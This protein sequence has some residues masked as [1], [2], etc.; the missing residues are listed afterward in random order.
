MCYGN[1]IY[2]ICISWIQLYLDNRSYMSKRVTCLYRYIG[3][4]QAHII[5]KSS[6]WA[7]VLSINFDFV[8]FV[9][10]TD[11]ILRS[12]TLK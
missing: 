7:R 8:L 10:N 5:T 9:W 1:V 2:K 12:G 4:F 6:Y 11:Q 3:H